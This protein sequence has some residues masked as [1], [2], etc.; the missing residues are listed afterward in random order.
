MTAGVRR[1]Q[2]QGSSKVTSAAK[3]SRRLR[4]FQ[5]PVYGFQKIINGKY[6]IRIIWDLQHG[7]RRYGEIQ[8]GLLTGVEGTKEV[9]PR[10]LSRELKELRALGLIDRRDYGEAP[11]KVE[12][13]LTAEGESLIPVISVMHAWGVQHL[14]KD[15]IL[16][17][18]G[19]KRE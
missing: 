4:Q 9:A 18:L 5:C 1:P 8:H 12:Y 14:V 19:I 15:S 16:N 13:K 3:G 10:V 7:P 17:K 11:P 2:P 6:K